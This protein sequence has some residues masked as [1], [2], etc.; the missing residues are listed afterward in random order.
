M[1]P[2]ILGLIVGPIV[3]F[4]FGIPGFIAACIL[5]AIYRATQE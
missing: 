4:F 5:Y 3:I 2:T 1:H